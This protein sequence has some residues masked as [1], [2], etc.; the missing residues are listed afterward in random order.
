MI[1]LITYSTYD[2]VR[3][4]DNTY[5][6][7][8]LFLTVSILLLEA[9]IEHCQIFSDVVCTHTPHTHAA[10]IF[11]QQMSGRSWNVFVDREMP[12]HLSYQL[13]F[14]MSLSNM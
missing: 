1:S 8:H 11:V 6:K 13:H 14:L 2:E 4:E 5:E 3:F 7:G 10:Q 9:I 12:Q